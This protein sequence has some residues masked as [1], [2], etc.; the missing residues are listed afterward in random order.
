MTIDL[1]VHTS[2]VSG[3]GRV[4]AAEMVRLYSDLGYDGIVITDHLIARNRSELPLRERAAWYQTGYLAAKREGEKRGL[5]V[6][7]GAEVR[8]IHGN[9]DFLLL[10]YGEDD[11]PDIMTML[12]EGITE[13][14][15]YA[16]VRETG[17]M[18]LIQAHPFRPG[19]GQAPLEA[20]DGIEV[21]NGHPEHDSHNEQAY[22]RALKGRKGFI[23]TS[24]SD[25]HEVHHVGRGGMVSDRPIASEDE[26]VQWLRSHPQGVRIET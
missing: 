22:A 24:G 7:R 23:M 20:L 18:L 2:E 13:A 10:G 26:L 14:D 8:F 9:E 1:H 16:W 19:L 15:F 3:C 6:L 11:L 12:D 21:Y 17:R 25:A 5:T 4:P